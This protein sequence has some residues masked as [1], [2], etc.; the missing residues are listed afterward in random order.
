MS[1]LWWHIDAFNENNNKKCVILACTN[2]LYW[3]V[4]KTQQ[5]KYIT[6]HAAVACTET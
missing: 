3:S 5:M 6:M 2:D 4:S 1:Q